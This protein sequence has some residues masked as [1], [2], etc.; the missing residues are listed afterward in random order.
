MEAIKASTPARTIK[1]GTKDITADITPTLI[2]LSYTDHIEG[3][4]DSLEITLMD[5]PL[6]AQSYPSGL[7]QEAITNIDGHTKA[8]LVNT[9]AEP[10]KWLTSWY[11]THGDT[12]TVWIGYEDA[13]MLP[14]GSFEID[15]VE[16]QGPPD[17]VKIKA[18]AAGVKRSVRTRKGRAYEN[19]NLRDIAATVA[20]RNKMT[21]KG[22]IEPIKIAYVAQAFEADLPFLK[23]V[24]EEYGYAFSVRGK[25]LCFFKHSELKAAKPI[26]T[27]GRKDVITYRF[28]DKVHG[29]VTA[30]TATYH[31]PR[32]KA[33]R[34]VKVKD[35]ISKNNH[36]SSDERKINVRAE[37]EAQAKA[38]ASAALARANDD[39]TGATLTLV[40]NVRLLAGVNF[41]L[42]E[43]GKFN[44]KYNISQSGHRQSRG[45]YTTEVEVKRVREVTV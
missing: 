24:S 9:V 22:K 5:I 23:R 2:E 42:T 10:G 39:Q 1:Y 16:L 28:H 3:E 13:P 29:V 31:D 38:K 14:C 6:H 45:G 12:L 20:K 7:P 18:L 15:E 32:A 25:D 41:M 33:V 43:F 36:T 17:T 26:L 40:G 44:G 11:P 27:I 19:T 21:L 4:S 8:V 30:A 35:A 37:T 34:T